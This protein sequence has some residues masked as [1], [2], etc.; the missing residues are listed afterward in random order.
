V[1]RCMP[2]F[3]TGRTWLHEHGSALH[4]VGLAR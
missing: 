1:K 4:A 2:D 3:E